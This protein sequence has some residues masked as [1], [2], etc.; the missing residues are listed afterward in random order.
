MKAVQKIKLHIGGCYVYKVPSG[1]YFG[2]MITYLSK[3]CYFLISGKPF[4]HIPTL[5]EFKD[6][7]L[8]G[9]KVPVGSLTNLK[10]T[11]TRDY[12]LQRSLLQEID[13]IFFIGIETFNRNIEVGSSGQI[14]SI[15]DI[16]RKNELNR[17]LNE[18]RKGEYMFNPQEIFPWS[19]LLDTDNVLI[20]QK[21][22]NND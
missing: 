7:G 21:Q 18:R 1:E 3:Y 5:K 13:N 19:V 9:H 12:I 15:S 8:W 4:S 11:L 20:I 2:F 6:A 22:D 10:I 16:A 17:L 14:V